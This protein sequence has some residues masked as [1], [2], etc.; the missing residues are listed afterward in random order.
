MKKTNQMNLIKDTA[1]LSTVEYIII[2]VLIA[3]HHEVEAA[4]VQQALHRPPVGGG[5]DA[6][7]VLGQEPL[8]QVADLA[9][10]VDD[11]QVGLIGHVARI[12]SCR[13]GVA[14]KR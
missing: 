1:G 9:V 2:L 10:V 12:A 11:E 5:V 14:G 7:A 4:I 13:Q 6:K 3:I 8:Q